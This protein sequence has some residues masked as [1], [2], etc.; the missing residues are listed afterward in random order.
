MTPDDL[1]GLL[2]AHQRRVGRPPLPP[3]LPGAA[4]AAPLR[5]GG[6]LRFLRRHQMDAAALGEGEEEEEEEEEEEGGEENNF[7][8]FARRADGGVAGGEDGEEDEEEDEEEDMDMAAGDPVTDAVDLF[9]SELMYIWRSRRYVCW[10]LT[11][12]VLV[13]GMSPLRFAPLADKAA[14][15][16]GILRVE[17]WGE[18]WSLPR[19]LATQEGKKGGKAGSGCRLTRV[20]PTSSSSSPP[21]S[22]YP[23]SLFSS[24]LQDPSGGMRGLDD[25]AFPGSELLATVYMYPTW[26]W[27]ERTSRGVE[28]TVMDLLRMYQSPTPASILGAFPGF[29]MGVYAL[30]HQGWSAPFRELVAFL[31]IEGE[32]RQFMALWTVLTIPTRIPRNPLDIPPLAKMPAYAW[33]VLSL[34]L[35]QG[36]YLLAC[37]MFATLLDVVALSPMLLAL[38]KG[39]YW[40]SE[41]SLVATLLVRFWLMLRQD[42]K[43][44]NGLF[45]RYTRMEATVLR[46]FIIGCVFTAPLWAPRSLYNSSDLVSALANAGEEV[47]SEI[48]GE[49]SK[50]AAASVR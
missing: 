50:A 8:R 40:R 18:W 47:V 38:T 26:G 4:G 43:M 49:V 27:I 33:T 34:T 16:E 1:Q 13:V 20:A 3:A 6:F 44:L 15:V 10:I 32:V 9:Q 29:G 11:F 24:T 46:M 22:F 31:A 30:T 19:C 42:T 21:P 14:H 39:T 2:A 36:A 45:G 37:E 25:T 48:M 17:T 5:G 41:A 7:R 23:S 28:G 35:A 12:V